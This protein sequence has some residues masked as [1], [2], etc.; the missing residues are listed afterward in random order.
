MS[1]LSGSLEKNNIC[2]FSGLSAVNVNLVQFANKLLG[3]I[4]HRR[5]YWSDTI[6]GG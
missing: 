4:Y 6:N 2:S 3:Y 5:I 1:D